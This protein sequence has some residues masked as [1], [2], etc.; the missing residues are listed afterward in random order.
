M[1]CCYCPLTNYNAI[2]LISRLLV[3][4]QKIVE[5]FTLIQTYFGSGGGHILSTNCTGNHPDLYTVVCKYNTYNT[6]SCVSRHNSGIY[7]IKTFL[8]R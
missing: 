8:I 6:M 7:Y 4:L 5:F 2:D 1:Y 3:L